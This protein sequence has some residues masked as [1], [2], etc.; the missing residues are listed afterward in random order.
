MV[1]KFI[2]M[3]ERQL[4]QYM[5]LVIIVILAIGIYS[6]SAAYASDS[7]VW[8]M[9]KHDP[10]HTGQVSFKGSEENTLRWKFSTGERIQSSP[11]LGSDGTVYVGSF[12]NNL[13]AINPDGTEKWRFAAEMP[14][15]STPAL[16]ADG[17]IYF[18]SWD[19]SIYAITLSGKGKWKAQTSD[20]ISSSP[21]VAPDGTIYIGADD[22]Y[23]YAIYPNETL[24]WSFKTGERIFSTPAIALDS[25]VYVGSFDNNLYAINPDGTE[26]WRFKTNGFIFSSAAIASDGTVYVG[27]YDSNLYALHPNGTLKWNFAAEGIVQGSPSIGSDGT[28]YV[29]SFD[30]NLYAINPDGTEKWRFK[31]NNLVVSSPAIDSEGTIYVGSVDTFLYAINPDGTE[32]WRFKTDERIFS[33]PAIDS[34]GTIYVGS[35]DGTLYAIGKPLESSVLRL[36][37]T[38]SVNELLGYGGTELYV[39]S[40]NIL[41]VKDISVVSVEVVLK[42]A[43]LRPRGF[44]LLSFKLKDLDGKEYNPN[45]EKSTLKNVRIPS[46]DMIRGILFFESSSD[47]P[48][49]QLIYKDI[50]GVKL[51]INLTDAKTHPD[52]EPVSLFIP[53][54]NIGK[55]IIYENLELTILDEKFLESDPQQYL[56][57]LSLKN[58]GTTEIT[59]NQTYTYVKDSQGN[60]FLPDTSQ[61]ST[62]IFGGTLG[63]GQTVEG[64]ISFIIPGYASSV[65]FVYDDLTSNSYFIVPEFPSSIFAIVGAISLLVILSKFKRYSQEM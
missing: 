37:I 39:A 64:E 40:T 6:A 60:V 53:G 2:T 52:A 56:I 49:A 59:Y 16:A 18:G 34:E 32:K 35:V 22:G 41:P 50:R 4:K 1:G 63:A 30:N 55:K 15:D 10:Q 8:S 23:V 24:K 27:S 12:D 44:D 45:L 36:P 43:D 31:T 38:G 48:I 9:Y 29:G 42:N 46:G 51:T 7:T 33:S 14:I 20:Q 47:K 54:S 61:T 57:R 19:K 11:T 65:V 28:V 5:K 21:T 25:T 17:T 3:E 13:Y 62:G 58:R 26:K